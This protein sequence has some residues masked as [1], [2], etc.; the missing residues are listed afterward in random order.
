[1]N[2]WVIW[3]LIIGLI[4]SIIAAIKNKKKNKLWTLIVAVMAMTFA[5]GLVLA[6][7]IVKIIIGNIVEY[8]IN[9]MKG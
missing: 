7:G 2:S 9:K 5:W 3:Y 8:K 1:M 6:I 4:I